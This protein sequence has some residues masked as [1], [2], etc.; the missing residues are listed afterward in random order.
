MAIKPSNT[1]KDMGFVEVMNNMGTIVY[2]R[3][4]ITYKETLIFYCHLEY[5]D[6]YT[7]RNGVKKPISVSKQFHKL[8]NDF[9]FKEL[10][11][12]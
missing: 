7:V 1:L 2:E 5:Y 11:W 6:Y 8:I 4:H 9:I 12:K 3:K 10:F